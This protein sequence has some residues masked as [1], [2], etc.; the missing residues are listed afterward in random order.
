MRGRVRISLIFFPHNAAMMQLRHVGGKVQTSLAFV[1]CR[2]SNSA[3][4]SLNVS[5][6]LEYRRKG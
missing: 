2:L 3:P 4:S 6:V 1:R 5:G